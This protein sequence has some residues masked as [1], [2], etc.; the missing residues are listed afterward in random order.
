MLVVSNWFQVLTVLR[1]N[2]SMRRD[3]ALT[4]N[5]FKLFISNKEIVLKIIFPHWSHLNPR[6]F[7]DA[8]WSRGGG[9]QVVFSFDSCTSS[10]SSFRFPH[11]DTG[12][13]FNNFLIADL[14]LSPSL[15]SRT[16]RR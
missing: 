1:T 5:P 13:F 14:W 15:T 7:Q 16:G 2:L 3:V 9:M 10:S 11:F 6:G 4:G 12:K 8:H